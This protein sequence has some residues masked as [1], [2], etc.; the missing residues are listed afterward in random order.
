MRGLKVLELITW[1]CALILIGEWRVLFDVYTTVWYYSTFIRRRNIC[2]RSGA[3]TRCYV[4]YSTMGI[5]VND[6]YHSTF[7][8]RR[9][10]C[11][12]SGAINTAYWWYSTMGYYCYAVVAIIWIGLWWGLIDRA[13]FWCVDDWWKMDVCAIDDG[14]RDVW[15]RWNIA[16]IIN[17]ELGSSGSHRW[18]GIRP[19]LQW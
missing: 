18:V 10:A 19:Q 3:I 16:D 5:S 8:Q 6:G 7:I 12:R 11:A 15:R 9:N 4:W 2:A 14:C 13:N 17:N 1:S